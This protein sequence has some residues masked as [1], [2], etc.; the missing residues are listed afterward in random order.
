MFGFGKRRRKNNSEEIDMSLQTKQ[1]SLML[2][3]IKDV[4]IWAEVEESINAVLSNDQS[5]LLV[6]YIAEENLVQSDSDY[7][8][9]K[10]VYLAV[11]VTDIMVFLIDKKKKVLLISD[12]SQQ[13][14]KIYRSQD[15]RIA[16]ATPDNFVTM[17]Y[18]SQGIHV[19]YSDSAVT[20]II[21]KE[22]V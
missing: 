10:D 6:T 13:G 22:I 11:V 21:T 20:K 5:P 7:R 14:A 4:G 12:G 17:E 18:M 1:T 9:F 8:Q 19:A 2:K 3:E 15:G 16:I